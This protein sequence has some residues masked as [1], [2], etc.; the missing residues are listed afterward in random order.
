MWTF[1]ISNGEV[2]ELIMNFEDT[3]TIFKYNMKK[4]IKSKDF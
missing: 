1:R 2:N 3:N 4:I